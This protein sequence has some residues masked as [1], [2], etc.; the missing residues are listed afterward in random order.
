MD[1][2]LSLLQGVHHATENRSDRSALINT[3]DEVVDAA[4]APAIIRRDCR[5]VIEPC[6]YE[7]QHDKA[8]RGDA[9]FRMALVA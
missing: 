5:S 3:I 2:G 8:R 4:N 6:V 9:P 7:T 1:V